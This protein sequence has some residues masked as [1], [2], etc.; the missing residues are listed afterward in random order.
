MN[1]TMK[2]MICHASIGMALATCL[3]TAS[4]KL[5]PPPPADPAKAE[6]AKQKAADAARKESELLVKYMDKA[7]VNYAARAKSEGKEFKPQLGPG[8]PTT[9]PA[10]AGAAPATATTAAAAPAAASAAPAKS[11]APAATGAPAAKK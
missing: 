8:A 6:E 1:T 11:A 9:P 10:P 4:A 2:A 7:A 3:G 5:P